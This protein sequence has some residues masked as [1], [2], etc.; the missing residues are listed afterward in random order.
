M[1]SGQ[2]CPGRNHSQD[3]VILG[4]NDTALVSKHRQRQQQGSLSFDAPRALIKF[5]R[6]SQ[7]LISHKYCEF[8]L[9][10]KMDRHALWDRSTI[11]CCTCSRLYWLPQ[12]LVICDGPFFCVHSTFLPN[13]CTCCTTRISEPNVQL[14][15][16]KGF[17]V[18]WQLAA[19]PLTALRHSTIYCRS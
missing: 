9:Q 12:G 5:S 11:D 2:I 18:F 14:L 19:S 10:P 7:R 1:V 8:D 15:I 13:F 4:D 16:T 3:L 6:I 17:I